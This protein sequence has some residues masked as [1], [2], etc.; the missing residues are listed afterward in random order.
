MGE[1]PDP[2]P[3]E[4]WTTVRLRAASLNHHDL[5]SLQGVGLPQQATD[6][7]PYVVTLVALFVFT[8]IDRA[9]GKARE[10]T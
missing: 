10:S 4:G 3:G 5:W 7:A 2:E 9:R 8:G 6:A 1:R